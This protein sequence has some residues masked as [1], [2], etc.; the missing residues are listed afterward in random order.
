VITE[1]RHSSGADT[2]SG[3]VYVGG[4]AVATSGDDVAISTFVVG[5]LD[6]HV[7]VASM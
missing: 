5:A 4:D 7:I 6:T 2:D 3:L 1:E